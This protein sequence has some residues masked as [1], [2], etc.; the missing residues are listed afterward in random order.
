MKSKCLA[1]W[2]LAEMFLVSCGGTV[3]M[4]SAQKNQ[5]VLTML[6]GSYAVSHE[7]GVKLYRFNQQ[8]G[9][10][11][12][13][14]GFTGI[15][16]PSFLTVSSGDGKVY[17]VGEDE[18]ETTSTANV[19]QVDSTAE[20]ISK[21]NTQFTKGGA[22]CHIAV[23]PDKRF[24]VTAN[25]MGANITVFPLLEN[26]ELGK[27]HVIAFQGCGL[28]KERQSQPHLHYIW[29][30]PDGKLLLANDLGKDCI[31]AF[32][33]H[34]EGSVFLDEAASFDI[35]LEPGSGPRH[36]CFDSQGRYAY[37]ITEL[38]GEVI[39]LSYDGKTLHPIQTVLAD[40]VGAHGS[41]DIHLSPDGKYLY[42]SNRLK[43]DGIAIFKVDG[44]KGTLK[45][46]G[47]QLTGSHPRNFILS[48]NGKYLLVACRDTDEIEVYH[49]D[50]TTGLLEDTHKRIS[51]NKPVCLQWLK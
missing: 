16:N 49:R 37:L 21:L 30:T 3:S 1:V 25:Y 29:F 23:S 10:S 35:C 4:A 15:S 40:T 27:G 17:V 34:E 24:V 45:K 2:C 20:K 12:Y 28:D 43:A 33:I 42:A 26:G 41:A 8:T 39:V 11:N 44:E 46:V 36:A 19:L 32:P 9:E 18:M 51:M 47:Y 38:S 31:H 5:N 14:S 22:P 50:D 48:P 7:E 13:V 6:V